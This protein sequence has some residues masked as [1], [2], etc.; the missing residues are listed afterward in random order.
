MT[1]YRT[2]INKELRNIMKQYPNVVMLGECIRDPYGGAC[3][4][5]RGLT[6][7]FNNRIF[8]TP[9]SEAAIIGTATGLSMGGYIPIV[10]IMFYDFITLCVDQIWNIALKIHQ[11]H[12]PIKI[13]IRVMNNTDNTYGPTHSQDMSFLME[14]MSRCSNYGI[15]LIQYESDIDI[16][17]EIIKEDKNGIW[18]VYEEK[19]MYSLEMV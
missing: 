5:T 17:E 2:Y 7:D 3:K 14:E 8:D 12:R 18:I 10:E 13:I 16:Y 15:K 4:V 11:L 6:E 1:T 19:Q 9:I